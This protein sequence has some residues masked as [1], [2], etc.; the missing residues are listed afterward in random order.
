[1]QATFPSSNPEVVIATTGTNILCSNI[2][3][4]IYYV[5]LQA[6]E[7]WYVI[8]DRRCEKWVKSIC[9]EIG[10]NSQWSHF[11]F[12]WNSTVVHMICLQ[13]YPFCIWVADLY[14]LVVNWPSWYCNHLWNQDR[15]HTSISVSGQLP[16]Y[17]SSNP[18]LTLI[19]YQLTVVTNL[20]G[21]T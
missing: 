12:T 11:E 8:F 17:P 10:R 14:T 15:I 13:P 9:K 2:Y 7:V 19:F 4:Q 20:N 1:M 5:H 6:S 21:N 18:T 16:T 3:L